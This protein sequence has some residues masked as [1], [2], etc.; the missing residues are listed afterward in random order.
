MH[1]DFG[2]RKGPNSVGTI[3]VAGVLRLRATRAVSCDK[4]VRRSAQDDGFV[5]ILTK[6]ERK[7][8]STKGCGTKRCGISMIGLHRD[9]YHVSLSPLVPLSPL[10]CPL[11][12]FLKAGL[13]EA[14][15]SRRPYL[16]SRTKSLDPSVPIGCRVR[17]NAPWPLPLCFQDGRAWGW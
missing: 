17:Q 13:Q 14:G 15:Q 10:I 3:G 1:P 8:L 6:V 4:S 7:V 9:K 5:G 16:L 11:S 12:P 2:G